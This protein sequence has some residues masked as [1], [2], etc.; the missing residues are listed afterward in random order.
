MKTL[1]CLSALLLLR[2]V[3]AGEFALREDFEKLDLN[4][5]PLGYSTFKSDFAIIADPAKGKALKIS[6]RGGDDP[7]FSMQLDL[8]KVA[9]H[10]LRIVCFARL[11]A[12]LKPVDGKPDAGP[13]LKFIA[14]DH[15][16]T[17]KV[18]TKVPAADTKEWQRLALIATVD[19]DAAMACVNVG[20]NL[21]AGEVQFASLSVEVDPDTRVE[22]LADAAAKAPV[23]KLELGGIAFDP[24][25]ADAMQK[26]RAKSKV[27]ANAMTFAGP[28]L[29]VPELEAKPPGGWTVKSGRELDTAPRLLLAQLP[30]VLGREKPEIV[31]LFGDANSTRKVPALERLDWEDVARLCLRL[32]SVPV[33]VP[34]V[35]QNNEDK[36]AVRA[37]MLH[38]AE[39]VH[40]P[41]MEMGA[42]AATPARLGDATMLIQKHVFA[43]DP[44]LGPDG[45]GPD[46][47]AGKVRDE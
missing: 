25:I 28:G 2:S 8:N 7:E 40:C 33:L 23:R 42:A 11:P 14:K 22:E 5:L 47:G 17:D 35:S 20:L 44:K 29:P 38:G 26:T 27:N 45:R 39:V 46:G 1:A 34:P 37:A 19:K 36:D 4:A 16:G 13:L 9:G 31:F 21:S 10:T 32:G 6:Q 18:A 24:E 43:R 15:E 30:E 12:A 41:V 3:C